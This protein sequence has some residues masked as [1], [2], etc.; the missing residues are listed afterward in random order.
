ME[1]MV[2][3]ITEDG[4]IRFLVNENTSAFLENGAVIR[5]ASHVEPVSIPLRYV[6]HSLRSIFGEK[7][8]MVDFTRI[9]PCEWRINLA[10]INGPVLSQTYYKRAA[11]INAEIEWLN[12]NFI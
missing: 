9:W 12:E 10:P 11:A 8:W 6:F 5:R 2:V 7:G 3:H 4:T 1:A